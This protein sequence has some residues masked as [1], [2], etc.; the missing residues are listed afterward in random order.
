RMEKLQG[1]VSLRAPG[2]C[3]AGLQTW[4]AEPDGW[5][6]ERI[7]LHQ[8]IR[9]AL[10]AE[11]RAVAGVQVRTPQAGSYLFVQL[12][13]LALPPQT[14]VALLRQQAAATVTPGAEFGPHTCDSLR[15]NFSQ[16]HDA[17]LAAVQRIGTLIERYR[18]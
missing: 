16:D 13:A 14:F 9:D 18:S 15:L 5:L 3:Q 6:Q 7:A 2:Y 12:P 17:A 8:R 4:F 1:F 11:F 10:L